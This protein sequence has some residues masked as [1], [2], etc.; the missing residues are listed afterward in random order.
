MTIPDDILS[1]DVQ[2]LSR[3]FGDF[4][5][6][7]DVSF[8]VRPGEIF[9]FLGAN[10]AGKSTTIRMLCGLLAPTSG[11]ALVGGIDV[12][13]EPEAVKRVI[14][15]MSQKFSL[16]PDLTVKENMRFFGTAYG[17]NHSRLAE[18]MGWALE[19]TELGTSQNR[20]AGMLSAG[21]KQ[22]L[23]LA[24]AVLHEPRI[25]FLDEPTGGVDP[26]ARRQFWALIHDLAAQGITVLVTTHYLDEAEYCEHIVLMQAGKVI[27]DGTP[28]ELKTRHLPGRLFEIVCDDPV[29]ALDRFQQQPDVIE[30]SLFGTRLHVGLAVVDD[31]TGEG[32]IRQQASSWGLGISYLAPIVPSLEDV[33]I[34]LVDDRQKETP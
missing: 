26:V 27:A 32:Y 6:V 33:F 11:K 16:Y 3:Y 18:R 23:A 31:E 17:L 24:C 30:V 29:L 34:Y 19:M 13:E 14:G 20:L 10:G 1:I 12:G 8:G 5:A 28:Q 7:D 9:G 2:H 21:W 15:Y 25:V 22:R 4:K